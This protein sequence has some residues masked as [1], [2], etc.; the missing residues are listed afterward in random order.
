MA[1]VLG[2]FQLPF[3]RRAVRLANR[4]LRPVANLQN[5]V[6]LN[7]KPA[8]SFA[9]ANASQ[10]HS[11]HRQFARKVSGMVVRRIGAVPLEALPA[12]ATAAELSE[13]ERLA[14]TLRQRGR[15]GET[16]R[17]SS[18]RPL[19]AC[20]I[21]LL[22]ALGACQRGKLS[23]AEAALT[24]PAVPPR[25]QRALLRLVRRWADLLAEAGLLLPARR[26]DRPAG[27]PPGRP[28][29]PPRPAAAGP[30]AKDARGA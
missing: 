10:Y 22:Q 1:A 4:Q 17:A 6:L 15:T 14:L 19:A 3:R 28:C 8:F 20:E 18:G 29:P 27:M 24:H 21:R 12:A 30:L 26:W 25:R 13:A 11:A 16:D 23:C 9:N 5:L 7:L 2:I